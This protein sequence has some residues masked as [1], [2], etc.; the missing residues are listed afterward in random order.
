MSF[1]I[2]NKETTQ[3][4]S[5]RARS[6]G[7]YVESFKTE[8]AAKAALTRQTNKGKL[9]ASVEVDKNNFSRTSHPYTKEDFS[10]A[11]I[12]DFRDNIEKLVTRKNLMSGKDYQEPVN[13]H[14]CVSPASETY[15]SS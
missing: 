13:T 7:C 6:V 9:G 8:G 15:W 5:I 11:E 14:G 10:I 4:L 3:I 12:G 2:Y 1:V